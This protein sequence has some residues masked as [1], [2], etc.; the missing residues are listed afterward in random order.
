ML[1]AAGD[2]VASQVQ[3]TRILDRNP[4]MVEA[5]LVLAASLDQ[6]GETSRARS[7]LSRCYEAGVRDADLDL[8]LGE[9][10]ESA[11]EH[12]N[13]SLRFAEA[14]ELRPDDPGA[15]LAL[16]RASLRAGDGSRA[17]EDLT[18]CANGPRALDCRIELARAFVLGPRDFGQ[19]RSAL[20][21]AREVA[22]T[23]AARED[24]D[25]RLQA[26]GQMEAGR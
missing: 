18:R 22:R 21:S 17:I 8:R 2:A 25:R 14:L 12:A 13:A 1:G 16:G 24:V 4:K 9:Q 11:G 20:L 10:L 15:L 7:V 23:D 19:A 3:L 5:A 6:A 26:L